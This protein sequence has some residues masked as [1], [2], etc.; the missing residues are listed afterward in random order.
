[1]LTF[2]SLFSNYN[3]YLE[4]TIKFPFHIAKKWKKYILRISIHIIY[5]AFKLRNC[6]NALPCNW[7][8]SHILAKR[9]LDYLQNIQ[10]R[11][12]NQSIDTFEQFI[13]FENINM[14]QLVFVF[15]SSKSFECAEKKRHRWKCQCKNQIK[16]VIYWKIA[17]FII[18]LVVRIYM[19]KMETFSII[20]A[21]IS[22]THS[23]ALSYKY[24]KY[25][26]QKWSMCH[27]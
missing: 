10:I 21:H 11:M 17:L 22:Q 6:S 20:K 25:F 2:V 14:F 13:L 8:S 16:F 12:V 4:S 27:R 7:F 26:N 23:F 18:R 24:F 15:S 9:R 19:R 5:S 1:M 3:K